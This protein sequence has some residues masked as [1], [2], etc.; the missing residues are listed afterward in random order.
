MAT[1]ALQRLVLEVSSRDAQLAS[2]QS[3]QRDAMESARG[4][5]ALNECLRQDVDAAQAAAAAARESVDTAR[6]A[7]ALVSAEAA[8]VSHAAARLGEEVT[9]ARAQT[10]QARAQAAQA[11]EKLRD[12]LQEAARVGEE[13]ARLGQEVERLRGDVAR[14]LS[15]VEQRGAL[16]LR[17]RGAVV[18]HKRAC[19]QLIAMLTAI[20]QQG[21]VMG[22]EGLVKGVKWRRNGHVTMSDAFGAELGEQLQAVHRHLARA[23]QWHALPPAV[24][25]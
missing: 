4:L 22:P 18:A 8:R 20:M 17:E 13:A 6:A 15:E 24:E 10:T 5:E 12:A 25:G 23:M 19:R 3:V 2:A 21:G 16:L 1:S 14:G 11:A 7:A 9:Q